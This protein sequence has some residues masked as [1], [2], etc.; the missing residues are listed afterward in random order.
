MNITKLSFESESFQL[1]YL[2]LTL[3]FNNFKR[4][5][6][7]ADYLFKTF[8]CNSVFRDAKD[9]TKNCTLI[10]TKKSLSDAEF[11]VNS[12]K[13]WHGTVLKFSGNQSTKLYKII[14]ETG[15]LMSD[16][17]AGI[18]LDWEAFDF[19]NTNVSRLDVCYDRKLKESDK[20]DLF[21]SFG[22]R[23]EEQIKKAIF[24]EGVIRVGERGS[25]N[26]FRA[27]RRENGKEVRFELE[28]AD[29]VVKKFQFYLFSNQFEKL[30]ELLCIHFYK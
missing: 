25:G 2:S 6:K 15:R 3:Q 17:L 23:C 14:Q 24:K 8:D 4:I 30:E 13:H 16:S 29:K 19:D 21:D 1:H 10:K 7:L 28:L 12:Q 9:S 18:D 26:Y 11:R 20:V 27:Y 22:K 5:K